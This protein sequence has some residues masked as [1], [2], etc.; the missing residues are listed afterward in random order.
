[1]DVSTPQK[2]T[3]TV[4]IEFS[5]QEE[6]VRHTLAKI[7]PMFSPI[8]LE[9]M[10]S[11]RLMN[12]VDTKYLVNAS[13]VPGLLEKA[14]GHYRM[15]EIDGR[16]ICPYSSIY[17]DTGSME[18]YRMHHN[19]KRHRYKVRMRSYLDSGLTFL[20]VKEK[21]N[22]GRTTKKRISIMPEQFGTMQLT[23][24]EEIFLSRKSPY[25][26]SVLRP[27]LQNLFQRITLVDNKG[28]ERVTLDLG[29][30]FKDPVGST[31]K[32]TDGFVI[33]EIKQD[34]AA[35]SHFREYLNE[36]KI[37]PGS[38]SKYCLGMTMIYPGLK[39]NN[40]KRKI[41]KINKIAQKNYVTN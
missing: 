28:T 40:F 29:L 41:R 2:C 17:F 4:P 39:A 34:G 10:D 22:K 1:M 7:I 11:V 9:E 5:A 31:V 38:M 24:R 3:N 32:G 19:G 15:V 33:I 16:R 14:S 37:L 21:S 6:T 18:M 35:K 36:L 30:T 25:G 20:E 26:T 8:T 12:R 13:L 23:E 27:I